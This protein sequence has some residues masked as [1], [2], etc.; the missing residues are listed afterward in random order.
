[1]LFVLNPGSRNAWLQIG[2]LEKSQGNP[3]SAILALQQAEKLDALPEQSSQTL[4]DLYIDVG[5]IEA[6]GKIYDNLAAQPDRD[7]DLFASLVAFERQYGS[8][9][10]TRQY[11]LEWSTK[12]PSDARPLY[13]LGLL[14][15]LDQP[16]QA[17]VFLNRAVEI[18]PDYQPALTALKPL[19][20]NPVATSL[21]TIWF[22]LAGHWAAWENGKSPKPPF[23][24]Q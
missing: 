10:Q 24:W 16:Q 5:D 9:E 11:L 3:Q 2:E 20:S 12:Y 17:M 1:M 13:L 23:Y 4:A 19:L 6:A 18:Q 15:S 21:P 22:S 14:A 7:A 8:Q